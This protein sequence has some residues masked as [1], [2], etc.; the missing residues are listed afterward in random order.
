MSTRLWFRVEDALPLAE[1]ALA[2]PTHRLTRAQLMAGEHNT[3]ALALRR[4]GGEGELRSNGVP[5]WYT[6]HGAEQIAHGGSWRRVGAAPEPDEHLY[7]PLRHPGPDGRR[8]IDMLRA[9]RALDR[10]WIAIDT[11]VWPGNTLDTIR[12]ELFDHRAEIAPP[13]ARWRP[14]MVTSPKVAD[15]TYPA[16]VADGYDAGDDG[17]LICR[18]DP[19]TTRRIAEDLSGPRRAATTPG[20]YPLLRFDGAALVLLDEVDLVD[21][22]HRAVGDRCY[23][24][25][26]GYYSIGAHRWLWHTTPLI[27]DLMP[28]R[29]R[30]RL[31]ATALTSRLR[32]A[33]T[34]PRQP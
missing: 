30:L 6:P 16:L 8:L 34:R 13:G 1:H 10:T 14:T 9:G 21:G 3:P 27:E 19:R 23:P 32:D 11:D 2:C 5:V 22:A 28:L 15:G 31:E 24:D 7:L 20:E 12:V 17:H 26:D 29:T 4:R 18:F 33:T 25:R